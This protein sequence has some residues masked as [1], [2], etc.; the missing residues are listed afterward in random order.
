MNR[1]RAFMHFAAGAGIGAFLLLGV[2]AVKAIRILDEPPARIVT[3]DFD[4]LAA[5]RVQA[6]GVDRQDLMHDAMRY[7]ARISRL[8]RGM[9]DEEHLV[10]LPRTAVV[11]GAQDITDQVLARI[12]S[13]EEQP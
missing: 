8:L 2:A 9:A 3:V 4:R 6:G 13:T 1:K 5:A 11:A 10:I 12:Q 7:G